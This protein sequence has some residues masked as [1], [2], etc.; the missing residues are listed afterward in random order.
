MT[1]NTRHWFGQGQFRVKINLLGLQLLFPGIL[2]CVK[3]LRG[4]W[5]DSCFELPLGQGSFSVV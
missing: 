4:K 5:R 2:F 3:K 1:G